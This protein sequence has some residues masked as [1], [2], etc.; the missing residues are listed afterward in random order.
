MKPKQNIILGT[1]QPT[2]PL[3]LK[4]ADVAFSYAVESFGILF[5]HG[6]WTWEDLL[7]DDWGLSHE[8]AAWFSWV[9]EMCNYDNIRI[10]KEEAKPFFDLDFF[11]LRTVHEFSGYIR[12]LEK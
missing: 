5:W 10:S 1:L 2:D 6:L 9:R 3:G 4:F 8:D 12:N 11:S 7:N